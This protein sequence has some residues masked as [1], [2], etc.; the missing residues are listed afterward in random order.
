M[1]GPIVIALGGNAIQR[2][3]NERDAESQM[4]N[5]R[6][7]AKYLAELIERG[8]DIVITHGNGPQVGDIL[9]RNEI[10]AKVVPP[11]PLDVCGAESQGMIGYWIQ[12]ALKNELERRGIKKPIATIVTQVLVDPNDPAFQNPT[13]FIGPTYTEEEAKKLMEK[14]YTMKYDIGRGGW[15]RVVPSPDPREIIEID[16]IRSLVESGTIVIA[17]GGGGIPVIRAEDGGLKGVEAV[18]DKDLAT[19]RLATQLNAEKMLILTAI[20]KVYLNFGKPNAKPL[21]LMTVSEAERYYKEGHF[22][23]GSMGP[24]ILASIRFVRH[25]GN[26]AIISSL[27]KALEAFEERTGTKIVPG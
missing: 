4:K 26:V 17:V 3:N 21:D 18:I 5:V 24:K 16:A 25:T 11:M 22:P 15:R 9:L 12:Q 19:E 14:G 8:V 7:T 23:P 20:E 13:K 10:S 27:D 2:N 1:T 6:L